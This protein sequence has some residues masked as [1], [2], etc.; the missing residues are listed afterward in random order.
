MAD[1]E[2]NPFTVIVCGGGNA[3]QV[4]TAM[5]SARYNTIAVSFFADEAARWAAA[6]GTDDYE[7]TCDTGKVLKSR[8]DSITNDPTVAAKADAVVLAV[9]SFAH[10]EYFEKFAPYLRPG[11]VIATMPA[12]SGG[13]ILLSAKLGAKAKDMIFVGFETLPWACRFTEWGRKATILGTKGSI[14]AAVTPPDA[15]P[16]AFGFLQGLLGCFPAIAESPNNLGV[17]LRNPGAVIH[18]GVMYGRWCPEKWDGS[19]LTEKPLFY[20]GVE[21]FTESVLLG[22]TEE[23]QAIRKKVE[24]LVPGIDLK[25]GCHLYQWYL[26]SYQ[27]QM[28]DSSSLRMCMN[29]NPGYRGLTHPMKDVDGG[30]VPDLKYRYLT[31]DV[32]TGMCFNKGLGELL[33]V[34]MPMTD[35]V[36]SWAQD[37]IGMQILQDGKM[38]GPDVVKTRA[39]QASGI[40]TVDAFFAAAKIDRYM[41]KVKVV[42]PPPPVEEEGK[43]NGLTVLVCGGGNAA[44]VG[45]AMFASRFKTIA[46]SLYADEAA[47]WKEA[48]GDDDYELTLDTGKV[49]KSKPFDITNDP[50]VAAQAKCI[51]LAV[52]SFAH[53]QYFEAFAPYLKP[54]TVIATM[55]ARSGGDILLSAKLGEKA[56]DMIFVGFETLPWACRFTEWGRKATILGTKGSILAAVTPPSGKHVALPTLQGLLGVFPRI[57]ESPNNLGI[58]LRNPGAVIHPGVMYGRWCPE[59]WNGQVLAEKP[60][61]YQGVEDFSEQV[62]LGLTGEV[63]AVRHKIEELIPGIDLQDAC[64]LHQWYLDSY[65]GQ[66]TDSSTLRGC[67]NTNPGYRGL[68]H[69]MKEVEGGFMPD[70][71]YRYLTE[72]VPT[73]MC[74]N[75]GLGEILGVPMPMTDRVLSWAQDCIGMKIL[76]NGQMVGPDVGK[77]RAPQASGITTFDQFLAAAKI[78]KPGARIEEVRAREIFDSRGNPTVEVDLLTNTALFRAAVPS[79][80]STGI[81]EA[82]EMRDGDKSRLLGK[83][84]LLAVNNVNKIIGPA[85]VGM[86]VTKQKEIDELMVETLDGTQNQW[87]WSKSKLGANAILAVS[88]AV[89]RAGAAS[90]EMPLYQYLATLAG[91][92]TDKFVMPVPA[93]NVINGGSHAGNRLACQEFMILPVGAR[94]FKE[95][96]VIGAEVY[97]K[98]KSCIKKNYGQDAC[99]VGDEGGFAPNVQ[100][101]NEALDVLMEALEASGH[102]EKVKIGTDVAASEFYKAD[103]QKYDLDFKNPDGSPEEMHLSAAQLVEYYKGWMSKYP[104][105]SI[106]DPFDQD[107]WDAYK[108]FMAEVG[109][110]VQIVGDDLLVTNPNRIK[111]A[112]EVK[113]CNALLLK[114][115]QIGSISEAIEAAVMSQANGWGVMV[116]HRSGETEDSFIADLVVGLR[117]G[118][119]KTGAPCRSERLAKY[120]Q[121]IRIEEELGSMCSFAGVNFRSPK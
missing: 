73:G 111:K 93:F 20:Q 97:H 87:G 65:A 74:F 105:V 22:L 49:L 112:L 90:K 120:N 103:T 19:V 96:M 32:P 86:D 114:V 107:D 34:P 48:L 40:S 76:Q 85:L 53:G 7:L 91:K 44:Q 95:A 39:P 4:A 30:F 33:G 6:L 18:P 15:K 27:G 59:Q 1:E 26:D 64:N 109:S 46:V 118:Q 11:T 47:K 31:E 108:L 10:G 68:T 38:C 80:A 100:D 84:V 101:N 56:K 14:L 72:D 99:N 61:F 79:G 2:K 41:R 37:C 89:A 5:F 21:E 23:V 3:A 88:M 110:Q 70:L 52:P 113:A 60:L 81:Y 94:T 35:K 43:D 24:E 67:M 8:P 66:M 115:N 17:S 29:T 121:L 71:R 83:G 57:A 106:E 75:K 54:G 25:D 119:I 58:S 63:Q 13:D 28:T 104:L 102:R 77:T 117:T 92:P 9:P 36:L 116:S 45:T 42:R 12:R 62:L 50:S 98:L 16:K 51:V 78:D 69:P 55:P 82:L